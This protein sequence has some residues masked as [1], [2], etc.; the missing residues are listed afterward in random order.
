MSKKRNENLVQNKLI[1][2]KKRRKMK[3]TINLHE[4][5]EI[6]VKIRKTKKF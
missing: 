3:N 2:K 5:Y 1:S 4:K 6:N